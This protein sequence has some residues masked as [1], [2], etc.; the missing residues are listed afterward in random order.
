VR[1]SNLQVLELPNNCLSSLPKAIGD[2]AELRSLDLFRNKLE[3]PLP[4][5]FSQ[6]SSLTLLDLNG[7]TG[8]GPISPKCIASLQS[9]QVLRLWGCMV[10][11][12]HTPIDKISDVSEIEGTERID[13]DVDT[14]ALDS[15]VKHDA[16]TLLES[17]QGKKL[18]AMHAAAAA[19]ATPS[20]KGKERSASIASPSD[21]AEREE[22]SERHSR[23]MLGRSGT[24][25]AVISS[26]AVAAGVV[27][28][29][30]ND[31][32]ARPVFGGRPK[33]ARNNVGNLL[34]RTFERD[35]DNNRDIQS[36]RREEG[37]TSG[38]SGSSV[39][40]V[41]TIGSSSGSGSSSRFERYIAA[42][43][44]RSALI[45]Q[46]VIAR[47]PDLRELSMCGNGLASASGF[48]EILLSGTVTILN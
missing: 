9:L 17:S 20:D 1:L 31:G 21:T 26:D 3:G 39:S 27:S 15:A 24:M 35:E 41:A 42:R 23:L 36:R 29:A 8:L 10:I 28:V 14:S 33:P 6:L 13:G 25:A 32:K 5:S 16:K 2:L 37:S 43:D 48:K 19:A 46:S 45:L 18:E 44:Q 4:T 47:L 11:T 22:R 12:A 38:S 7:N 40:S 30:V 34:R